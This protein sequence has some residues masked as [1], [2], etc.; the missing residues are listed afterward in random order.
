MVSGKDGKYTGG[1]SAAAEPSGSEL[2]LRR[3]RK[4]EP[5]ARQGAGRRPTSTVAC[6]HAL[7]EMVGRCRESGVPYACC[8]VSGEAD[9]ENHPERSPPTRRPRSYALQCRGE[10]VF[11]QHLHALTVQMAPEGRLKAATLL[12]CFSRAMV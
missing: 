7:R 6:C 10:R 1:T 4:E 11:E 12:L 2:D 8:R 3:R 5:G 9:C